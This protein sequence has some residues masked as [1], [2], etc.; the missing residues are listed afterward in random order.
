MDFLLGRWT[1]LSKRSS[2]FSLSAR[3]SWAEEFVLRRA[4]QPPHERESAS[5]QLLL[6][7]MERLSDREILS[8]CL[9]LWGSVEYNSCTPHSRVG[10]T[11]RP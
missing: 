7:L 3:V 9:A 11:N 4:R 10:F 8:G 1:G 6:V 2:Y 5:V